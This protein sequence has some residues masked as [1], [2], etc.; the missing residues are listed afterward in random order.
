M[1]FKK[2]IDGQ[3]Q[4]F[5]TPSDP[6]R[7]SL[8]NNN[9]LYWN[10]GKYGKNGKTDN[11]FPDFLIDVAEGGAGTSIHSNII[12][13][14][15]NMI[16]GE[17]LS[18]ADPNQQGAIEAAN[19]INKRNRRGENL[20]TS[21]AFNARQFA[22]FEMA[23]IMVVYSKDYST[24][25][26]TY[27][28]PVKDVRWGTLDS[29]G[30]VTNYYISKHWN[31]ISNPLYRKASVK[32]LATA[33]PPYSGRESAKLLQQ[34]TQLLCIKRPDYSDAYITPSWFGGIQW[35]LISNYIANFHSNNFKN[36]YFIQGMLVTYGSMSEDE[37]KQFNDD[38]EEF[39][40]GSLDDGKKRL[41]IA[42]VENKDMKPEFVSA[43]SLMQDKQYDALITE[44]NQ[45]VIATHNCFDIL[46]GL[47][48][49]GADLGGDANK[50]NT[51]LN[52]FRLLTTDPLKNYLLAGYNM[53]MEDMGLPLLDVNT[54][55]FLISTEE[56]VNEDTPATTP[57]G[58]AADNITEETPI[59]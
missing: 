50:L 4:Y 23:Y 34:P 13:L 3:K 36:N 25:A 2:L 58:N 55:N 14:K 48:G 45:Q 12:N 43:Q 37:E 31:D 54:S 33:V 59:Q 51:T 38:L 32:N 27:A 17:N 9:V 42:N 22:N 46:C 56:P 15:A 5:Y 16:T 49:K 18:V 19:F 6:D 11:A 21:Y 47:S 41:M 20:M 29:I 40:M 52:A 28:V 39:F 53:L 26:E 57:Q 10:T 8:G 24:I 7:V 44:A 35:V 1:K 30:N